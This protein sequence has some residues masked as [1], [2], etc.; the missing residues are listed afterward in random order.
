MRTEF[1]AISL[2]ALLPFSVHASPI[3]EV[4]CDSTPKLR[5]KLEHQFGNNQ[6]AT[7]IRSPDQVLEVWTSP[8]GSWTL[9]VTYSTGRSCIVAMGE[10]WQETDPD[11]A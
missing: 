10:N 9:V 4:I 2:G 3:A 1:L 7:G 6:Q 8:R 5:D 11:P